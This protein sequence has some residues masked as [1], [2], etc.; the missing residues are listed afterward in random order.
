MQSFEKSQH[1]IEATL[2][3]NATMDTVMLHSR[4]IFTG[5]GATMYRPAFHFLPADRI[6]D[7][8]KEI[9][10]SVSKSK[11]ISNV[12]VQNT[13]MTDGVT[14]KPLIIEGDIVGTELIEQAGKRILFKLGD[15]I[16]PQE[17][18]YQ[19]K[20]RRLPITIQY[21]HIL[22]RKIEMEIPAGYTIKNP[23][24]INMH[25]TGED[26]GNDNMGFVS[27]YTLEGNKLVVNI[28][29][30]YKDTDYPLSRLENFKKVINAAADFNKVVLVLEKK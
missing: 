20:A 13:A 21:P 18:M 5:Y 3:F 4:Q 29:E 22:D 9:I 30:Y 25:I 16:G 11:D 1:N 15:V 2:R 7:F 8:T 10:Q 19:E 27:T 6:P 24:D 23:G 17:E 14:N 12:K 26:T 28:H